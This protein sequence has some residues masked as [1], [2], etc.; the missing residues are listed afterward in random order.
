MNPR[1]E[2]ALARVGEHL[3]TLTGKPARLTALGSL[4][5]IRSYIEGLRVALDAEHEAWAA[6]DTLVHQLD[7]ENE[8]LREWLL[9]I[10]SAC[11]HDLLR[12]EGKVS[13]LMQPAARARSIQ[14]MASD[15][16][17]GKDPA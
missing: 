6:S 15:A 11:T 4:A 13:S 5:T 16:L 9:R 14:A 17:E 3:L 10:E 8:R 12:L 1:I 7:A 2:E